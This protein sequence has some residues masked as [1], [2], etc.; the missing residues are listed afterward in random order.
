[1]GKYHP[2]SRRRL[3]K[4]FWQWMRQGLIRVSLF[5][6]GAVALIAC[7]TWM[8]LALDLDERLRWFL[9][10]VVPAVIVAVVLGGLVFT[11]LAYVPEAIWHLRGA[12]GEDFTR[13]ELARAKR[14]SLIW[15]W[16]DS[17]TVQGGDIDHLVV[18]RAAGLLAIDSK[19]RSDPNDLD[20]STMAKEANRA[21]IRAEG[22]VQTL[23]RKERGAHRAPL[24]SFRVTPVVVVWGGAHRDV[25]E[26]V[27]VDGVV[28]V[29]GRALV[30]WLE[31]VGGEAVDQAAA[32][33]ILAGLRTFRSTHWQ[34]LA[35]RKV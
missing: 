6:L 25:P 17:L 18:T 24:K 35:L 19:W 8:F 28:F 22:V 11:F 21:R 33:D 34:P 13:D 32:N 1:M 16:V 27:R 4:L 3:R 10:G 30:G 9:I 20:P 5:L 26:G 7:E 12:W 31:R 29:S 14:K 2:Y 23:V 15:D